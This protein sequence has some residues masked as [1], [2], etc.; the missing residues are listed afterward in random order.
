MPHRAEI[1]RAN[2]TCM[3]FLIDQSGS[4]E[5]PFGGDSSLGK[6]KAVA[7]VINRLLYNLVLRNTVG[8]TVADRF[9]VGVLGYGGHG[10]APAFAGA[11][12]N[13]PLVPLSDVAAAPA[14]LE[15]R[16]KKESDGAG[17]VVERRV[18][19]PIWFEPRAYA[20]TPMCEALRQAQDVLR[21]WLLQ[22][23]TCFPPI[24]VNITDGESTDGDPSQPGRDLAA[25]HSSDGEVLFFNVHISSQRAPSVEFPA[26]E[27]ALPDQYARMLFAMSSPLLP[28]M[29]QAARES[30]S[31]VNEGAR[32]FAFNADLVGLI[33]F[34]DIGTRTG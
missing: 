34:L 4:M 2:P 15:E 16:L 10:V 29:V 28:H 24:A 8:E 26:D 32:G 9:H 21:D 3:L 17:G 14:R 19:F 11:L 23:P 6:N 7:D 5:A 31:V 27:T 20:G 18:R 13:R 1:S 33:K 22:H 25:L 30:G 12:A